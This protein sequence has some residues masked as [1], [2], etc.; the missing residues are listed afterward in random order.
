VQQQDSG[1]LTAV[2]QPGQISGT[3]TDVNNSAV[4]GASVSLQGPATGDGQTVQTNE[5]GFFEVRNVKPGILY[6]IAIRADGFAGWTSPAF[7]LEPG[8]DKFLTSDKLKIEEIHTAVTVR[9]ES[10][11][12]IA[13]EEVRIEEKQRAFGILPNFFETFDPNPQPLTARLK[14]NLSLRAAIDPATFAGV[15]L[16]AGVGQAANSPNYGQ[17]AKGFG[18]RYG[19]NYA[20]NFTDIFIGGAIL[21]SLLH[22]DPRYYYQG[23]APTKTRALH[24]IAALFIATGDNGRWQPNYSSLG[25]DL[26]SAAISNAYY[27]RS[28]RGVGLIFQNFAI[29]T[30][31]HAGV[32]LMQEFVFH[33]SRQGESPH[34]SP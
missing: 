30:L 7:I 21:P 11:F 31:T 2:S 10:D 33:P 19:A 1:Q 26:A 14:F 29:N 23:T 6:H 8:Q 20:N 34:G 18:M 13:T 4:S 27:P 24:A 5:K 15:A 17:G 12:E 3:V 16:L 32:R 28:N 25:G 9:A 22:Q